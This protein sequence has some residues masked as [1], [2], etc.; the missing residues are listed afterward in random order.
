ME[1]IGYELVLSFITL[2]LLEIILGIDNLIFISLVTY[3]L[4]KKS[5]NKARIFGLTLALIIRI[6]MLMTLSWIMTLTD[7]LFYLGDLGFS[8]KNFLLI[9][10]GLFLI[11]KSGYEIILDV[12]LQPKE[13]HED[14]DETVIKKT[15]LAAILQITLIDFIFSFDSVITAVAM[16]NN[17]PIIIAAI[18]ISMII[19]LVSSES[20]SGFLTRYPSLKIIA[21]A[22]IFMV[23]IILLADG[24]H[25]HIS[26]TYLYF[27]LFFT[28]SVE[29]LNIISKKRH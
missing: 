10:G 5:R 3:K 24:F 4:P 15:V 13:S 14:K 11:V 9:S 16:T 6:L 7:P 23:G 17:I 2:T 19:M 22:L 12:F 28:L 8:F 1:F 25:I 26:K 27:S 29:I 20:I 21:L 18:V